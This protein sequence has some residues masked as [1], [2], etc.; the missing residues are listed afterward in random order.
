[1]AL[2]ANT[3]IASGGGICVVAGG[4]VAGLIELPIAGLLSPLPAAEVA[5][6]QRRT[7]AAALA[8]G[9]HA[10]TLTQPLFQVLLSSLACLGGPHVTDVGLVDGTTGEIVPTVT[11]GLVAD[12]S[13]A[14]P[15]RHRAGQRGSPPPTRVRK[16]PVHLRGISPEIDRFY[17]QQNVDT[18]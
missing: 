9:L 12:R 15:R 17:D 4:E 2:A 3:V 5:E 11:R 8:I 10:P 1:M 7:Q 18:A 13:E 6:A 14:R 16:Q